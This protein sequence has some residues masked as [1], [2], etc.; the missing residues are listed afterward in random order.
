MGM[1]RMEG[2]DSGSM[3]GRHMMAYPRAALTHAEKLNLSDEQMGKIVCD[4]SCS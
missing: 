3:D 1:K 2:K 4:G